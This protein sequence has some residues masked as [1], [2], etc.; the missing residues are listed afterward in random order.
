MR[1]QVGAGAGHEGSFAGYSNKYI[2]SLLNP[3]DAH[4]LHHPAHRIRRAHLRH[5]RNLALVI[6]ILP[7]HHNA[8]VLVGDG[9]AF[10]CDDGV[11]L[12]EGRL[13]YLV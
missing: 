6:L 1:L 2:L 12:R 4:L 7:L 13:D 11:L 8:L 3:I 9:P 5:T 10:G